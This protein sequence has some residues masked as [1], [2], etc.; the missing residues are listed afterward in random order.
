[1][2]TQDLITLLAARLSRCNYQRVHAERD[3][4]IARI[5]TLDAQIAE[6]EATL[7]KL[8]AISG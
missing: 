1:M 3:G 8:R 2:N 4:D 5:A 6:I 7:N